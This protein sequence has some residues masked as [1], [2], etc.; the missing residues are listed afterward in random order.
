[1]KRTKQF[2]SVIALVI[3][4][5]L[6]IKL[7]PITL[8]ATSDGSILEPG[9]SKDILINIEDSILMSMDKTYDE[10]VA[11][12]T[13]KLVEMGLDAKNLRINVAQTIIDP[14][15]LSI[16]QV[17]DHYDTQ[18]P[19]YAGME[20]TPLKPKYAFTETQSKGYTGTGYTTFTNA[21]P[22]ITIAEVLNNSADSPYPGVPVGIGGFKYNWPLREHIYAQQA[23][24][25]ANMV[26]AGY[27]TSPFADFLYYPVVTKSINTVEYDIDANY[28]NSHSLKGAGFL[29]NTGKTPEGYL[30]GYVLYCGYTEATGAVMQ[31]LGL[32]KIKDN[33]TPD[34][35]HGG[36][37]VF[38]NNLT[39]V[40]NFTGFPTSTNVHWKLV[41][42]DNKVTIYAN[43]E[44]GDTRIK[45][46]ES[47]NGGQ[48]FK[49]GYYGFGPV[50]EYLSHSCGRG[51]AFQFSNVGMTTKVDAFIKMSNAEFITGNMT[52]RYFINLTDTVIDKN[53]LSLDIDA[54]W[55]GINRLRSDEI[56]YLTQESNP[57]ISDG[58]Q[59]T[60]DNLDNGLT[61]N[62]SSYD[63]LI[64]ALADYIYNG[65]E[66]RTYNSSDLPPSQGVKPT[67]MFSL[68]GTENG[69]DTLLDRIEKGRVTAD[70]PVSALDSSMA[71]EDKR[72]VEWKYTITDPTGA[73]TIQTYTAQQTDNMMAL[74]DINNNTSPAGTY[75][76]TL[77]VKDDAG[78]YSDPA[79]RSFQVINDLVPPTITADTTTV[80]V[81]SGNELLTNQPE[82][83]LAD[84]GWGVDTYKITYKD[85]DGTNPVTAGTV[86]LDSLVSSLIIK[87]TTNTRKGK[88]IMEVEATDWAGNV[89]TQIFV[90]NTLKDDAEEALQALASYQAAISIN[91]GNYDDVKDL[92][93]EA[94]AMV[95]AFIAD[96]GSE[97]ALTDYDY[98][99]GANTSVALYE[100]ALQYKLGHASVSELT[101][102]GVKGD[103]KDDINDALADYDLLPDEV[104]LLLTDM[105]QLLDL[106]KVKADDLYDKAQTA[107]TWL[108]T[109]DDYQTPQ[110]FTPAN[111]AEIQ[112]L[113][114]KAQEKVDN[115]VN[116]GGS[117]GDLPESE[118]LLGAIRAAEIFDA[119][120]M[121]KRQ[122]SNALNIS[123]I[124]VT[125]SDL[126]AIQSALDAYDSLSPDVQL[127]LTAEKAWLDSIK[128]IASDKR[129][130]LN[131][132]NEDKLIQSVVIKD[133]K[134]V[135]PTETPNN[136]KHPEVPK[137]IKPPRDVT[138]TVTPNN[139]KYP[140]NPDP[141]PPVATAESISPSESQSN[142]IPDRNVQ[143]LI[144]DLLQFEN[145]TNTDKINPITGEI[146][147]YNAGMLIVII[148]CLV[149][150]IGLYLMLR[151]RAVNIE[152][153]ED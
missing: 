35:L 146:Q 75:T 59:G 3:S 25:L 26:F 27:G 126:P 1:M 44:S 143:I 85:I 50:V 70:I 14:T 130:L 39:L 22:S 32:Y 6:V 21:L 102:A 97:D 99:A 151:K 68:Y 138:P 92:I 95:N 116:A 16:W 148:G 110:A 104:K 87:D 88:Y 129:D 46:F 20:S 89:T 145:F 111:R 113:I 134:D 80:P 144:D 133:N 52:E 55:D 12:L 41:I 73:V 137:P 94:I 9:E 10:V 93:D 96:G 48:G 131:K 47:T 11:D 2:F 71:S 36:S 121:F 153:K 141:N 139:E 72:L 82:I 23:G 128:A 117:P 83:V 53:D 61:A 100:A 60:G 101:I 149:V 114:D 119:A 105:K 77:V 4:C 86:Q 69:R 98:L 76:V 38:S 152:I 24:N 150:L 63:D 64:Q 109:L 58:N 43:N 29:F 34:T 7:A 28:V 57:I 120:E 90:I 18:H 103:H 107:N 67:A 49:T 30:K 74:F 8:Q 132:D 127:L 62:A 125:A 33:V 17:Y 51:T 124:N 142:N 81:N 122:Q 112:D 65:G 140:E 40:E 135:T 66:P 118:L 91:D 37:P 13:A 123:P 19:D 115:Y 78:N 31:S 84:D 56:F 147:N 54:Y 106:L 45:T 5:V 15:D 79:R 136:E 42:N 108:T